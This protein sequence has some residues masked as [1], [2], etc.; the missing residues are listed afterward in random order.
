MTKRIPKLIPSFLSLLMLLGCSNLPYQDITGLSHPNKKLNVL[1]TKVIILRF[2]TKESIKLRYI[3]LNHGKN[4]RDND[5]TVFAFA[6]FNEGT[7]SI[8]LPYPEGP[9]DADW[10][11]LLWHELRHCYEGDYHR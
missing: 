3:E 2:D 7:C 1:K 10:Q 8:Y 6:T 4:L 11:G 5:E 9:K